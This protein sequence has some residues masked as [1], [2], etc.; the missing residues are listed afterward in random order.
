MPSRSGQ[1]ATQKRQSFLVTRAG[2]DFEDALAFLRLRLLLGLGLLLTER[3]DFLADDAADALERVFRLS[4][5]ALAFLGHDLTDQ[6]AEFVDRVVF[7][8]CHGASVSCERCR[9]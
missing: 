7:L 1:R 6:V 5:L 2:Q 9:R 4:L 8:W 3:P